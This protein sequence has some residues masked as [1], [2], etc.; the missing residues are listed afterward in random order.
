M[1][2][3]DLLQRCADLEAENKQLRDEARW[4]RNRLVDF[5]R[6]VSLLRELLGVQ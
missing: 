1:T 5:D 3:I 4:M 6:L 2:Q